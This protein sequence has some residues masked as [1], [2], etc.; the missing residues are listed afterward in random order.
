[1]VREL[2][3][4]FAA[5]LFAA[6]CFAQ[7]IQFAPVPQ[8][9]IETRLKA[10]STKNAE[11]Q[12]IIHRLFREAACPEDKIS[13]MPVAHVKELDVICTLPGESEE[14]IVV[15]AH[16][17]K[18]DEGAGVVDNWSGA[19]LLSSLYQGLAAKPRKHTI[20]F[21]AFSGEEKGLFGSKAYV[22]AR[23][24]GIS[25]VKAMVNMDTLGLAE[26]EVW[27]SH[28]DPKMVD[29]ISRVASLMKLPVSGMNV[30]QVGSSDS[31]S[32]REAHV[33]AMTLHSIN[34][35]TWSILHSARD[36][37][38]RIKFDA[39]YRSYMLVLG[40]LATLDQKWD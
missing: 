40:F 5:S 4:A 29:L 3:V 34:T 19:S 25:N 23:G 14:E 16:F 2:K 38:D 17:D 11:R 21:A 39:Y 22:K 30:D 18:V 37:I 15:G 9:V 12:E 28:A 36:Q 33:P 31:E 24:K 10:F 8:E 27:V 35:E 32:F 20:V 13:E 7:P 1:M 6:I 26:T